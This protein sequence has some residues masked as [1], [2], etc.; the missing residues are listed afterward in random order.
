MKAQLDF[1]VFGD[2][3]NYYQDRLT[4]Q[5]LAKT[6]HLAD[7][8]QGV[9]TVVLLG[10]QVDEIAREYISHGAHRVLL[11]DRPD[12][13][14]YLL[15]TFT[16][17]ISGLVQEYQPD[18]FMLGA[19]D[20]GLEL[21]P[22]LAKRLNVGLC[23]DCIE[24]EMDTTKNRL[25][26][27]SPAFGG[28]SLARIVWNERRP[29]MATIRPGIFSEIAHDDTAAGEVVRINRDDDRITER[30]KILSSVR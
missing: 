25:V 5:V 13:S 8:H 6:R 29:M 1:W 10:H 26:A 2:H 4:L 21:A 17:V 22:R 14:D 16:Q 12:M 3:R 20:F 27:I 23:A 24:F 7:L 9:V 11:V 19:S 30:V 18:Y 28:T 15:E